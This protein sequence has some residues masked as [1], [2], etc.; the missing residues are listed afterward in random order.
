[1]GGSGEADAGG[2][3]QLGVWKSIAYTPALLGETGQK[4][5]GI[6]SPADV[7]PASDPSLRSCVAL[8]GVPTPL[9]L[10][11]CKVERTVL[12]SQQCG[13]GAPCLGLSPARE[14]GLGF[15][16]ATSPPPP[17]L[18]PGSKEEP[19]PHTHTAGPWGPAPTRSQGTWEALNHAPPPRQDLTSGTKL[20]CSLFSLQRASSG[21]AWPCGPGSGGE[22]QMQG[23]RPGRR[24]C[25]AC[26]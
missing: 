18:K 19:P 2:R 9:S 25:W 1:M 8:G 10:T 17:P 4:T 21:P 12:L 3:G 16:E 23:R 6:R 15:E 26:H 20:F 22:G 7:G 24:V 14:A 13:D 11:A 5:S